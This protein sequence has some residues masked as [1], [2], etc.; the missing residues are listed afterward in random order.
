MLWRLSTRSTGFHF[1]NTDGPGI[2]T[3]AGGLPENIESV[4]EFGEGGKAFSERGDDGI[5]WPG[6]R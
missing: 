4:F 2:S 6:H 5:S 1:H 3:Y